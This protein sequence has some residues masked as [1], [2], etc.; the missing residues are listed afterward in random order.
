MHVRCLPLLLLTP[1]RPSDA[2]QRTPLCPSYEE[3][4][5]PALFD[6]ARRVA[7]AAERLDAGEPRQADALRGAEHAARLAEDAVE[8]LALFSPNEAADDVPTASLRYLLLPYYRGQ[9]AAAAAPRDPPEHRRDVLAQA[10][11]GLALFLERCQRLELLGPLGS[12]LVAGALGRDHGGGDDDEDGGRSGRAPT[13]QDPSSK[14]LEKI[15]RFK[16]CAA[17]LILASL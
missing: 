7:E 3:L 1:L 14:R 5:L 13:P 4:P 9:L 12:A 10:R 11:S 2:T 16:R 8:R 6:R 15:Q 17:E